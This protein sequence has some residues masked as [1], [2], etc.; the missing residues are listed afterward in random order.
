M[1]SAKTARL[2]PGSIAEIRSW[3]EI[4]STLDR[5]GMLDSLPFMPEMRKYCGQ[6]FAVTK[7]L[8]RTCE[9]A[10]GGMRRIR[11]VVFLD[12]L[13]CDGSMHGGCQKGCML[14]WREAWLREVVEGTLD[15]PGPCDD[16]AGNYPFSCSLPNGQ[17]ICQSTELIRA[18]TFLSPLDFGSYARD[19][20][21]KTY[22]VYTLSRVLA[23]AWYLRLRCLLTGRSYRV[24]EGTRNSTP[25]D[26]LILQPGEW[27][28]VKSK[29]EIAATLDRNGKNQGLAFTVEMVQFCGKTF[30]VL[31]RL[32]KMIHE[33]SRKLIQV[34]NTVVL[35]G[36]TCDGCHILRGG[37]PREN[38]HFWRE[39]WLER[40]EKD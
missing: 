28:R 40:V 38:Y 18:T 22:S 31:K 17:Y 35:D 11:D 20:Q 29:E 24:V 16:E 30:R 10:E 6:R 1:H 27:V 5:E 19:I 21:A 2:M 3:R 39:A 14:F 36:V 33:P 25:V 15:Q 12:N 13:R 4:S 9:E 23:Y 37:C 8:E 34:R 7:R 26:V 32:E